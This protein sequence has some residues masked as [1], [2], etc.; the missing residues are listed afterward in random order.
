MS[1]W[2]YV[3]V[4]WF[5]TAATIGGYWVWVAVRTRRAAA[6]VARLEERS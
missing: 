4:G 5:V 1:N 2:G 3:A 6:D